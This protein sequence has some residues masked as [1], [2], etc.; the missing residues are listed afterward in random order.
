MAD[1]NNLRERMSTMPVVY[2]LPG[3]ERAQV[4]HDLIYKALGGQALHADAGGAR[5]A[6]SSLEQ[7]GN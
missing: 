4:Q 6:R 7:S 5:R 2:E 1:E 3:M